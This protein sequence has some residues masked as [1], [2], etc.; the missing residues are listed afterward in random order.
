M[1]RDD[2]PGSGAT[3]SVYAG[4]NGVL[5]KADYRTNGSCSAIGIGLHLSDVS[6]WCDLN[7]C[8]L[9]FRCIQ[10]LLIA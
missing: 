3:W 1:L 4:A 8:C 2:L 6:A 9:D 7:V 5:D 10:S